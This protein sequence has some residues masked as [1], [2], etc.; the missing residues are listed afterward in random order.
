MRM[1][2]RQFL[3]GF[4]LMGAAAAWPVTFAQDIST[5]AVSIDTREPTGPLPHVW[6]ECVGSDRA[7]ITLRESWR[8]DLDRWRAETG[9]KRVRFHGIFNDE[10]GVYSASPTVRTPGPPNFQNVD[11]VYDGLLARG[12]SPFVELSFMPRR[13]ASADRKFGF[14][15]ANVSPPASNEAWAAFVKAFVVHLVERYGLAAVRAWP[16]E[17]WNEANLPPFWSGTQ[18]QYF[19]LYKA[20]ALAVKSVD[21]ALQVGGPSTARAQWVPELAAYCAENN[22]PLDFIS[23]H[24]YPGDSQDQLFGGSGQFSQ[25]DVISEAMRRVRQGMQAANRDALPLWLTEWSSDSP[26]MIGHVIAGCLPYCQAMSQWAMSGTYEEIFVPDFILREGSNGWGM[27]SRGVAL[28]SFNTYKLLHAL[29]SERLAAEGPVLASR[30]PSRSTTALVWNLA[31]VSQQSGIPGLN[32]RERRVKGEAKQYRVEFKG[33]HPGRRVHVRFVDQERGSPTPAWREMGSPQ[34]LKPDQ[35]EL[36]RKRAEIAAPT[37][38]KLDREA[39]LTLVLPPEGV[40]LLE[41]Q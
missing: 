7:A 30:T 5:V 1:D 15:S 38:L 16:F 9:I 8:H 28:P 26:A 21:P 41:L 12:V 18:Q 20:T 40:A 24:V 36:L 37:V 14:Y 33:A 6:E 29:G 3:Q 34:Y 35:I 17:V 4:A 27:M 11:Q 23:T 13:L 19:D 2:R 25:A 31:E 39:A 10:L 22:A 32:A